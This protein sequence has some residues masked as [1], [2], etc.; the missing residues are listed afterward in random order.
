[1]AVRSSPDGHW[2]LWSLGIQH[3]NLA[4]GEDFENSG[5]G[6][7]QRVSMMAPSLLPSGGAESLHCLLMAILAHSGGGATAVFQPLRG[8]WSV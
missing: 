7:L 1:M 2:I 3:G 8:F 6:A 5:L 4:S